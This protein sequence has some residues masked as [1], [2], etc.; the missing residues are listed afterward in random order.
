MYWIHAHILDMFNIRWEDD[1]YLSQLVLE[2]SF[3]T[4]QLKY[5]KPSHNTTI[6]QQSQQLQ[7]QYNELYTVMN[8][9]VTKAVLQQYVSI[10][11]M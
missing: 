3:Q 4:L 1:H 7:Q 10:S 11:S 8:L 6:N 5:L 2:R 9:L